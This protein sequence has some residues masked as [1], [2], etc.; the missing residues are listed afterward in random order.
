MQRNN[1]GFTLLVSLLGIGVAACS[2]PAD[3]TAAP[4]NDTVVH[5][6][7]A[8]AGNVDEIMAKGEQI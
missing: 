1:L 6:A 7:E 2:Q 8:A 5:T 4:A 3:E